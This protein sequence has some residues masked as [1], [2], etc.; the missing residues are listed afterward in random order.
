MV[1]KT[2]KKIVKSGS[3]Q[4][5]SGGRLDS[6]GQERFPE[7]THFLRFE[8]HHSQ[9]FLVDNKTIFRCGLW[10]GRTKALTP[11]WPPVLLVRW[12]RESRSLENGI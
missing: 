10:E 2:R 9:F 1:I 6:K 11:V 3:G 5:S 7:A 4:V 12:R 8:I